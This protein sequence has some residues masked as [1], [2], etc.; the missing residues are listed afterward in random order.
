MNRTIKLLLITALIFVLKVNVSAQN[1][2]ALGT[3]TP[4]SMFGIGEISTQGTAYNIGMG[5]IGIGMRDNKY[6][7]YANPAAITARDTLSFMMDFGIIQKNFY[8]TDFKTRSAYNTFN[9]HNFVITV[10]IY[11]KSAFIV[12]ITPFSDTG[13]KFESTET[14][15][16]LVAEFGDIK[17]QKFGTGSIYQLFAGASM[18]FAKRFSVGAE[19]LYY[20]GNI[21]RNSN[22]LFNSA[23]ST[24]NSIYTG[25]DYK[26]HSFSGKFGLQYEQPLKD[27][28]KVITAG[29]TYRLGNKLKGD[30]LRFGYTSSGD[31][32]VNFSQN[33]VPIKIAS[34]IGV[35]F[36]YKEINKWS[37]GVDYT[38]QDWQ[39][40]DFAT[41]PGVNFEAMANHNIKAGFEYTPNR[42]DVR[43]YMKRIAYRGGAYYDAS[44]IGINGHQISSFGIT[45]GASLPIYRFYNAI[46]VAVDLGQRGFKSQNLVRER[47]I[48]FVVNIN[49]HDIWFQKYRYE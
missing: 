45:L 10:P 18:V 8:N 3:Y 11:R 6:I 32:L 14:D 39:N 35:G 5:G 7:N 17:Y 16:K 29:V 36:S 2:D 41:T 24:N 19:F 1:T 49:L 23:A 22:V 20:F 4:Y 13:Y 40:S 31:T 30:Y 27:E 26:L 33:D 46:S 37:V 44:Y 38:Y 42:Y 9:M 48:K 21:D 12:G 43:Y 34:E 47:Y 15:D 28:T 25:W